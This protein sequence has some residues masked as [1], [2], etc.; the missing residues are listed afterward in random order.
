MSVN[1]SVLWQDGI[2]QVTMSF[3]KMRRRTVAMS[4]IDL[5]EITRPYLAPAIGLCIVLNLIGIR[6]FEVMTGTEVS[7]V[8][9]CGWVSAYAAFEIAELRL[10]SYS[11]KDL[12]ILMP[13]GRA[14][15]MRL[16]IDKA[17]MARRRA[18]EAEAPSHQNHKRVGH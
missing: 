15:A 16:A 12:A 5:V 14:R 8:M 6:F 10:H 13:V 1:N 3:I 11:L 4:D 9:V 2:N 17:M 18:G 7:L